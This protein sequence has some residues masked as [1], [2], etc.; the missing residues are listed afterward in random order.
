M[1]QFKNACIYCDP[2]Y[3]QTTKYAVDKFDY[4]N[5]YD[6]CREVSKINILRDVISCWYFRN[7]VFMRI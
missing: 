5:F 1:S 7:T 4:N 2:P 6:W 3:K